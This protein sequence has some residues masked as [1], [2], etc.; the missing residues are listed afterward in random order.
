MLSTDS[1][2]PKHRAVLKVN[3]DLLGEILL[4]PKD[5]TVLDIKRGENE[6]SRNLV[7]LLLESHQ[8]P[9]VRD[10]E[11]CPEYMAEYKEALNCKGAELVK[12]EA[13]RDT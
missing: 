3:L 7:T 8:F 12:F 10:G 9:P 2:K 11:R 1:L 5:V 6:L 13:V 4:L